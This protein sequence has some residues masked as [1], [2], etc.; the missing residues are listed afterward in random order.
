MLRHRRSHNGSWCE[1]FGNAL[2]L[3]NGKVWIA[4]KALALDRVSSF[5]LAETLG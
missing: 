5:F 4:V 2:T 3:W 1:D